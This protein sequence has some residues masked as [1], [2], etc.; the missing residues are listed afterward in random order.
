MNYWTTGTGQFLHNVHAENDECRVFGCAIHNPT[1]PHKDWP[2][3]WA[4]YD[5]GLVRVNPDTGSIHIDQ[6]EVGWRRRRG[7]LAQQEV[8]A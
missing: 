3:H 7:I 1:D 2:T 6:D 4:G 5:M 8:S